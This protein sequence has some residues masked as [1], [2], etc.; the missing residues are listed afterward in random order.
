MYELNSVK[1]SNIRK[2]RKTIKRRSIVNKIVKA[3][4]SKK[5]NKSLKKVEKVITTRKFMLKDPDCYPKVIVFRQNK[6]N[7]DKLDIKL[8]EKPN[9]YSIYKYKGR[10]NFKEELAAGKWNSKKY[11]IDK[12]NSI[13]IYYSDDEKLSKHYLDD[14]LDDKLKDKDRLK[15]ILIKLND[16]RYL[17]IG[18]CLIYEFDMPDN[19]KIKDIIDIREC[20]GYQFIKLTGEKN[21]YYL[22]ARGYDEYWASDVY[23]SNEDK[24]KYK[25]DD[26]YF[27]PSELQVKNGIP[28]HWKYIKVPAK[29]KFFGIIKYNKTAATIEYDDTELRIPSLN[30]EPIKWDIL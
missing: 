30:V 16:T 24:I 19:D 25:L 5:K 13:F 17:S 20:S 4:Q 1:M 11:T 22:N 3:I 26:C 27:Y 2:T 9:G 12:H 15:Y 14:Y 10:V 28:F 18:E 23:V 21:T 6:D 7:P 8:Y 29:H